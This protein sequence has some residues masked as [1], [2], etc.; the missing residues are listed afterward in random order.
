MK[1][2]AATL[3]A[4]MLGLTAAALGFG[5]PIFAQQGSPRPPSDV[6]P[7]RARFEE[8]SKREIQLRGLGN[9]PNKPADP[10]QLQK[11][12]AEVQQ[13]F[14]RIL[15]LH[16]EIVRVITTDEALP[17]G[18]VSDATA[19]IRKRATHLQTLLPFEKPDSR[20]RTRDK[21]KQFS[22]GQMKDALVMLCKHIESFVTNPVIEN[23]GTVDAE[24]SARARSDL[25][26][27]IELGARINKS[28]RRLKERSQ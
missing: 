7:A 11:L 28:A 12:M 1:D 24:Q 22:D 19:E 27:L 2:H 21:R 26:D 18:F 16:N 17:V 14:E 9:M 25:A 4:K 13:D 3:S 23:P 20:E 8:T 6:D 5:I 10:K 15:T